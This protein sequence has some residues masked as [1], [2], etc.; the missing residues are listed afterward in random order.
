MSRR[1]CFI[2]LSAALAS[3]KSDALACCWR[4]INLAR[5]PEGTLS[6]ALRDAGRIFAEVGV[7]PMWCNCSQ[8]Q[9]GR[10]VPACHQ[11]LSPLVLELTIISQSDARSDRYPSDLF[12]LALPF[13]EG[14]IRSTVFYRQAIEAATRGPV[15]TG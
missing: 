15:S 12:G 1:Q 10:P 5:V 6:S 11:T 9:L 8:L 4:V 2:D 13:R 3:K 14:G 7:R